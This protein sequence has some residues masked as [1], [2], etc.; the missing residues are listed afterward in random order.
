VAFDV[1]GPIMEIEKDEGYRECHG[2]PIMLFQKILWII[3][4][5]PRADESAMGG[6][7]RPL[8]AV[9]QTSTGYIASFVASILGRFIPKRG[10]I[11]RNMIMNEV[12]I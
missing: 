10:Q 9:G 2:R 1:C 12:V 3:K 5:P 8:L 4:H 6:I 11:Q 7:N